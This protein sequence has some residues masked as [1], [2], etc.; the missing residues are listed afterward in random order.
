MA[1]LKDIPYENS[2][3]S[4]TYWKIGRK[5]DRCHDGY[6]NVTMFGWK[7]KPTRLNNVPPLDRKEIVIYAPNYVA[8][9]SRDEIYAYVKNETISGEEDNI[10]E[11]IFFGAED[12]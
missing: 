9:M 7:D 8:D 4:C 10:V 2:G 5:E 3:F 12:A 1:I 6:M 11:G